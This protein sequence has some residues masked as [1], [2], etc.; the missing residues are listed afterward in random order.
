LSKSLFFLALVPDN[1]VQH[2]I[3][4]LKNEAARRFQ[5]KHALKSPAHITI[6]PPF[7]WEEQKVPV[8]RKSLY[9]VTSNQSPF[10]VEIEDFDRF[11]QRVIFAKPLI[12]ETMKAFFLKVAAV[13]KEELEI[14]IKSNHPFHPHFTIAFKDLKKSVFPEAWAYFQNLGYQQSFQ[15]RGLTLLRHNGQRWEEKETFLFRRSNL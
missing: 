9:P 15:A 13:C 11:D 2:E 14:P 7:F 5:S 3:M 8:L 6:I 4:D 12:T 10:V 1:P